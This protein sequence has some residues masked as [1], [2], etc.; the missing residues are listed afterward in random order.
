MD[1]IYMEYK[2]L[3]KWDAHPSNYQ[4][5]SAEKVSF[6]QCQIGL[7]PGEY[8]FFSLRDDVG[9]FRCKLVYES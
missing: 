8:S 9:P 6:S 4:I 7:S 5:Q 1:Y 2:P 3:T